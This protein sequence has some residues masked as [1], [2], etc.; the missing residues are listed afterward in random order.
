[1]GKVIRRTVTIT[2]TETWTIV[3][4][5]ADKTQSQAIPV[6]QANAKTQEAKDVCQ[7]SFTQEDS[8]E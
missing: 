4:A 1:M 7:I 5:A 3:W 8:H 2:I 6:V